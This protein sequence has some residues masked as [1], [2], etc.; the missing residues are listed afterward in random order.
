VTGTDVDG[1]I[2]DRFRVDVDGQYYTGKYVDS[3]TQITLQAPYTGAT[4]SGAGYTIIG[5]RSRTV[6]VKNTI[7]FVTSVASCEAGLKF[8]FLYSLVRGIAS[9][10]IFHGGG[11]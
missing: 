8:L 5:T 6:S 9:L 11:S 10:T 4:I 1:A 2:T 7:F 3:P